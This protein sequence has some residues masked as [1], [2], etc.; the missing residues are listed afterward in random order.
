MKRIGKFLRMKYSQRYNLLIFSARNTGR[1]DSMFIEPNSQ[2]AIDCPDQCHSVA[3]SSQV[4]FV[5]LQCFSCTT[6]IGTTVMGGLLGVCRRLC[7][8]YR[9]LHAQPPRPKEQNWA[10]LLGVLAI[11]QC[12]YFSMWVDCWI[13]VFRTHSSLGTRQAGTGQY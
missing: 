1:D 13:V 6:C 2:D 10:V 4:R 8:Q 9:V 12:L 11:S 3:Y 5:L 7:R